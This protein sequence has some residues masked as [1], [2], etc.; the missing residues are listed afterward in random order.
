MTRQS[1]ATYSPVGCRVLSIDPVGFERV[2]KS[3]GRLMTT[4]TSRENQSALQRLNRIVELRKDETTEQSDTS[5][6]DVAE[7][8]Q[9]LHE[10]LEDRIDTLVEETAFTQRE[11]EVWALTRTYDE[12]DILLTHD[13]IALLLSTPDTGFGV[14]EQEGTGA[15]TVTNDD[16][17]QLLDDAEEKYEQARRLIGAVT[18]PERDDVL[19]SPTVTWLDYSTSHEVKHRRQ[20]DDETIDD[21]ISRLLIETENRRSLEEFVERYLEARGKGN[22]SQFAIEEEEIKHGILAFKS[23]TGRVDTLPEFVRETDAV[24]VQG[25]RFDIRFAEVQTGPSDFRRLTLYASDSIIG[26]DGVELEDGLAAVNEHV[27]EL[28][29]NKE[30]RPR[31]AVE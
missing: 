3:R 17:A 23:H 31:H 16:V 19:T 6:A 29:K 20:P 7:V 4:D 24:T 13:A 25:T 21:I 8:G 10:Q 1:E 11:A 28:I 27:R 5:K 22:V 30:V 12:Q 2:A 18:F 9:S 26:M 14:S 15:D